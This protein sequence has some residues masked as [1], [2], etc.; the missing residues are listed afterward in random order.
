MKTKELME[1][2]RNY[3][4]LKPKSKTLVFLDMDGV[5]VGFTKGLVTVLND[6]ISSNIEYPRSRG[7]K[8]ENLR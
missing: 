6:D 1:T 4:E 5:I 8:L 3:M 2:W 7:K